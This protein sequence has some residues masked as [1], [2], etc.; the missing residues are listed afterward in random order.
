LGEEGAH[1]IDV[2]HQQTA[3]GQHPSFTIIMGA[4]SLRSIE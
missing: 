3:R 1:G 4:H 2:I